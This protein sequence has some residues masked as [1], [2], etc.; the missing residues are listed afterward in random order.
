MKQKQN[1]EDLFAVLDNADEETVR[2]MAEHF[3]FADKP[4]TEEVFAMSEK[5]YQAGKDFTNPAEE[6]TYEV[7]IT[8]STG[9]Y[10]SVIAAVACLAVTVGAVGAVANMKRVQ[11][12]PELSAAEAVE[13]EAVTEI[14][15]EAQ[16]SET[17]R[18]SAETT[19]VPKK[20]NVMTSVPE[21][22]PA[23]AETVITS[24]PETIPEIVTTTVQT[25]TETIL[26]ETVPEVIQEEVSVPE[27]ETQYIPEIIETQSLPETEAPEENNPSGFILEPVEDENGS[28]Y[29]KL[30]AV[31]DNHAPTNIDVRYA[32]TWL[33]DGYGAYQT[34]LKDVDEYY[35]NQQNYYAE[36]AEA[37]KCSAWET[38]YCNE[39]DK[40][41]LMQF[42]RNSFQY[43]FAPGYT[44]E[45]NEILAEDFGFTLEMIKEATQM[46]EITVNGQPGIYQW[47]N[48]GSNTDCEMFWICDGYVMGIEA[49]D[50]SVEDVL[51]IAESVQPVQ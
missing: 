24:V 20:E 50:V 17:T 39:Q 22:L 42:C 1:L 38:W 11:P 48:Q 47:Q 31:R 21:T 18:K 25:V 15:T 2:Y 45:Y 27:P 44:D 26:T 33:P 6:E 8:R 36:L 19:A 49:F 51:R 28:S 7:Q 43:T 16:S 4:E 46:K 14:Q 10:K 9:L 5:K 35:E 30:T 12:E 40:L 23:V 34:V 37:G 29:M 13:T 41:T 32:V 3:L